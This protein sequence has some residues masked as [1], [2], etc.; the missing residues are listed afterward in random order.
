VNGFEA[1][2]LVIGTVLVYLYGRGAF[3]S[4]AQALALAL[5]SAV[6]LYLS[7]EKATQ[8]LTVDERLLISEALNLRGS[9]LNQW[10]QGAFRTSSLLV[11]AFLALLRLTASP[12]VDQLAMLAKAFHWLLGV[13]TLLWV[14]TLATRHFVPKRARLMFSLLFLW[15]ALLIP[16]DALALK[17]FNY[18]L[19]SMNLAVV[20]LLYMY[21]A[22]S[23]DAVAGLIAAT[24]AAQEKLVASPVLLVAIAIYAYVRY[25]AL[26]GR[27]M[28]LAL[29]RNVMV[30]IAVSACVGALSWVGL[31]ALRA[32][33]TDYLTPAG[34]VDHLMAWTWPIAAYVLG[35]TVT[36][37]GYG[38]RVEGLADDL[39]R[40]V[41]LIRFALTVFVS[42]GAALAIALLSSVARSKPELSV[43]AVRWGNLAA[44]LAALALGVAGTY[45]L[46]ATWAPYVPIQPDHYRPVGQ[47]NGAILHFG[48][49]TAFEHIAMSVMY[50]YAVFV[51]AV[52]S[53]LW[54]C[55]LVPAALG[56]VS[57]HR[58]VG[59]NVPAWGG[60]VLL[61][62]ALLMPLAFGLGQIPVGNKYLSISLLLLA[63]SAVLRAVLVLSSHRIGTR[64]VCTSAIA[65]LLL[66][67]VLPFRPVY[68]AFRPVW[69]NYDGVYNVTP[70]IGRL[71]PSWLGWGEEIMIAGEVLERQC[72]GLKDAATAAGAETPCTSLNLYSAYPGSWLASGDEFTVRLMPFGDSWLREQEYGYTNH[73]YYV[74]NRSSIVQKFQRFPT[75]VQPEFVLAF[76]GY[77]QAWVFRGDHLQDAGFRFE[78]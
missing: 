31:I 48:A 47:M 2:F 43:K 9:D 33:N 18:D 71:N 39:Q 69:A 19:L 32:G 12:P 25:E 5:G 50:A 22:V 58:R 40:A 54:L 77:V 7:L 72:S 68:A 41:L 61:A 38:Y 52:P 64:A 6:A 62:L 73:D 44:L 14:C 17:V 35:L 13:V 24:L 55:L 70:I 49:R 74:L 27:W 15:I 21:G 10:N 34:V 67:E 36:F 60:D 4:R 42:Y 8:F 75:N 53:V 29:A 45:R 66:W 30:G 23:T 76:R 3:E 16:T 57:S 46:T 1:G 20:A 65:G 26:R 51:N 78:D 37:D 63:L 11:G 56:L 28:L 59:G